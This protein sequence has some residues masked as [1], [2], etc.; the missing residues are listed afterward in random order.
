VAGG[1]PL[2]L[3][4]VRTGR[5][6]SHDRPDWDEVRS[7]WRTAF[8]KEPVPGPVHVG[9]LGLD[10]DQ[11]ADKRHHGGPEMAVLMYADAHYADW[12]A[13][14]GLEGMGP[15]GFG[16]NLTVRG[17][18]ETEVCV[19]DVL[20]VGTARLQVSSPRGPCADISRRWNASW[21]LA[22]VVEARRTGWYLRV[23]REGTVTTGDGLTLVERP[24]PGWTIDRLLALRYDKPRDHAGMAEASRLAAFAPEWRENFANLSGA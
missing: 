21:L 4:S 5:I 17:T 24:H 11:Q 13:L 8:W 9:S 7:E 16:E 2:T 14:A 22:K 18:D 20:D 15:G 23:L 19:G 12:R 1:T 6:R 10:G 3:V